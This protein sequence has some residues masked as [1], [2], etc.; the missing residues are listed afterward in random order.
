MDQFSSCYFC[1]GAVDASL[2]EYP[3]VPKAL[4]SADTD[5]PTVV[6]CSTCR[7]K[8]GAVVE[9][10]VSAATDGS[11]TGDTLDGASGDTAPETATDSSALDDDVAHDEA[12][13]PSDTAADTGEPGDGEDALTD[14]GET[15]DLRT[16]SEGEP[17]DSEYTP[18]DPGETSDLRTP[19]EG[20]PTDDETVSTELGEEEAAAEDDGPRLT[21]L[22]Y[23]KVMRLLQNRP[24]P[25]DRAEIR[26]V[27]TSAYDLD[28]A[29]FD[30]VVDAAIER[31]LIEER[32]GQFVEST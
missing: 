11:V 3:V 29:E 14:P 31:G 32:D 5:S 20:E 13:E 9:E 27:A 28:R 19:S 6:L 24:L 8:L 17:T 4:R 25:V 10:V 23:N 16:P 2:T 7:R 21:K 1:G 12:A 15:S 30:A 22:E 18:D 26:E